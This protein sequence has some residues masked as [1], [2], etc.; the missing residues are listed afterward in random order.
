MRASSSALSRFENK[1]E[2][3]NS[4]SC[5]PWLG[6]INPKGYG[7]FWFEGESEPAH[8]VAY[9]L[10]VGP[11]P[12]GAF[13]CHACDNRRCVNPAHLYAGSAATNNADRQLRGRRVY[14]RGEAHKSARLTEADVL[15]IRIA[16][17]KGMTGAALCRT[18][19]IASGTL[20]KLLTGRSWK[21]VGGLEVSL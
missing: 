1:V 7:E 6:Y 12:V 9:R 20:W 14:A 13:I 21:H 4:A 19:R 2:N 8:R 18:H 17:R 11:I 16:R 5:W 3:G 10:Y 15:A